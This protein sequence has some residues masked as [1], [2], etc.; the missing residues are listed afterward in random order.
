MISSSESDAD[1][2]VDVANTAEFH[3]PVL[4]HW[5]THG[6]CIW[7]ARFGVRD[8][9]VSFCGFLF[10]NGLAFPGGF[11]VHVAFDSIAQGCPS[12]SGVFLSPRL[13]PP[14]PTNQC[15]ES[16]ACFT[17]AWEQR[18]DVCRPAFEDPYG[19]RGGVRLVNAQ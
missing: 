17:H 18:Y 13:L 12:C 10:A 11:S 2:N 1:D 7:A 4:I 9:R 14:P 8:V 19:N 3:P 16:I 5:E 6:L 15:S